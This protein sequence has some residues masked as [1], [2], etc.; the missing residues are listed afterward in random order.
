MSDDSLEKLAFLTLG[1]LLGM[2][3]PVIVEAITR[4]RENRLGREALLSELR[5]VGCL[6]G[7]AAYGARMH[8]GTADRAFLTW[9]K[10]DL[11][12][13]AVAEQFR[14]FIPSL[15][16]HLTW[17]DEDIAKGATFMAGK[18]GQGKM[19]QKYPVP[20]LDAR[21]SALW[22]F[23]TSF[24]R[25]LL[26]IRQNLHLLDDLVDR[27]RTYHDITFTIEGTNHD[28]VLGNLDDAFD[29]YAE[30]AVRVVDLI[31]ASTS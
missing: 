29:F 13:N 31:R 20:L 10:S 26:S 25:Q 3:A 8:R 18:K 4:R 11:E 16:E 17:S 22:T 9:L 30:R 12:K 15:E 24:Q 6:V 21:V 7:V 14:A 5:E 1:W 19:L 27:T 23:E 2:L 28:R